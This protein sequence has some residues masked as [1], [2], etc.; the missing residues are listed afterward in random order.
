MSD[1]VPLRESY[2]SE[3]PR[4]E[5]FGSKVERLLLDLLAASDLQVMSAVHRVKTLTSTLSKSDRLDG[6]VNRVGDVHDV[7]GVRIITYF[8]DHVDK[9]AELI[10]AEFAPDPELTRDRRSAIDA[11]RFGYL[12]VHYVVTLGSSRIQLPEWAMYSDLRFEI[13]IRSVLQH[14]WAEIE[15]DLGYKSTA[16]SIP[17]VFRRRFSR[18][19]GLLEIADQEFVSLRTDLANF[20]A[21]VGEAVTA[22]QNAQLD[23]V[24]LSAYIRSDRRV[25]QIDEKIS[26]GHG[27]LLEDSSMDYA[28]GRADE[29][30]ALGIETIEEVDKLLS[31]RGNEI[32]DIAIAWLNDVTDIE[33]EIPYGHYDTLSRGISLFYLYLVLRSE[34]HTFRPRGA[35]P[36][37]IERAEDFKDLVERMTN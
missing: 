27:S 10:E 17:V 11:D 37:F 4:Y 1:F 35:E 12:S 7:L 2:A 28:R 8:S 23:Q 15:H 32:A 14:A 30:S 34:D 13:Q 24:S 9:V 16:G 25:R 20:E 36:G 18:L 26:A 3:A 22:G 5:L 21:S 6:T 31:E 19:A 29:L 33:D